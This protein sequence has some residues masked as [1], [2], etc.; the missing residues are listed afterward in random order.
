MDGWMDGRS[1]SPTNLRQ[2]TFTMSALLQFRVR[3]REINCR[4]WYL[5]QRNNLLTFQFLKHYKKEKK[6]KI[7]ESRKGK[8][9]VM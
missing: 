1:L 7:K 8:K 9:K 3:G 6:K 2:T 4:Y 5:F